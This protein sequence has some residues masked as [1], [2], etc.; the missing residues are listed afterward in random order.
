MQMGAPTISVPVGRKAETD[1][2]EEY[3]K[4]GMASLVPRQF[5]EYHKYELSNLSKLNSTDIIRLLVYIEPNVSHAIS[6]YLRV[7]DSG[8]YLTAKKPNGSTHKEGETFLN[9]VV[10]R[11]NS[12][13]GSNFV[14]DNSLN[15]FILEVAT[16]TL[17][18]GALAAEI[19]FDEFYRAAGLYSI[20]PATI[21][22]TYKGGRLVPYQGQGY[23]EVPLDYPTIFYVPVDS[24]AGDPYGT[25]QILSVIQPVMNKFRL[26]QDFARALH[27]LGFDRIDIEINQQAV[28]DSCK[29]RGIN[30]PQ[31]ILAEIN[32]VVT[33]S[34][35]S[36]RS[37]DA[38][39]NPVHVDL[40]KLSPLEGKN[41]SKGLDV[42]AVVNVLL[43][44]IASGLKTYATILGKR[45]GG[46]TEGYTS[47]EAL[48]FIKLIEGFHSICKRLLDRI[49]TLILQVEAGIQAYASWEWLEPSLRPTYE[50]AQYY[51]AF[52]LMLWEEEQLGAISQ[53][54]RNSMVRKMLRQKG[55]PP[56]DALRVDGFV[57]SP[58]SQP[59]RDVTQEPDKEKKRTDTNTDRKTG[60]GQS[61]PIEQI[62]TSINGLSPR[63]ENL[64]KIQGELG[65]AKHIAGENSAKFDRF[66][67]K[68]QWSLNH[69]SEKASKLTADFDKRLSILEKMQEQS[70]GAILGALSSLPKESPQ[71]APIHIE[72]PK[73]ETHVTVEPGKPMKKVVNFKRDGKGV[74]SEAILE[75]VPSDGV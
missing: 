10:M 34:T 51:A 40:L 18:D 60:G 7:F 35:T 13:S 8:Y 53:Q 41:A 70:S 4:R 19:E 45:F 5:L 23:G 29:S 68:T 64:E 14:P 39:D 54:E 26:L 48:L 24:I 20:D 36:L 66:A 30:D 75:E 63:L 31:L 12:P 37:L 1:F 28:I 43:S 46:S 3:S 42:Q 15:R 72:L 67:D 58:K 32:R 52:S 71:P 25:N 73:I 55:P 6:N 17:L 9:E 65:I 27:N 47:V 11:L 74:M 49:F 38:D 56:S 44:E 57:P 69:L 33:E 59:Q 50:S 2:F 16:H 61:I 21:N 62:M 22:F